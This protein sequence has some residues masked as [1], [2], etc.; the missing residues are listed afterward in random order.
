MTAKEKHCKRKNTAKYRV[1]FLFPTVKF[2]ADLYVEGESTYVVEQCDKI[3][4]VTVTRTKYKL[5]PD[6]M[7]AFEATHDDWELNICQRYPH[8]PL[9]GGKY[10]SFNV[11]CLTVQLVLR[12]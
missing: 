11:F 3:T 2:L 7:A 6:A 12:R 5:S 1:I 4:N 10:I 9:I 8:D